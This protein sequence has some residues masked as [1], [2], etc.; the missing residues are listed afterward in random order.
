MRKLLRRPAVLTYV[1]TCEYCDAR[2]TY[3]WED[4]HVFFGNRLV[5]CPYCDKTNYAD[6]REYKEDEECL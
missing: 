1:N 4:V 5:S 2:Y 3:E 6:L